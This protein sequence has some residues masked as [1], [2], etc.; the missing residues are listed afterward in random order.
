M[1]IFLFFIH[2]SL[3]TGHGVGALLNVHEVPIIGNNK[4]IELGLQEN[5]IVTIEPGFYENN[6][7][8]IRIENCVRTIKA[9]T[10]YARAGSVDFLTFEPL[11]YVPIQRELIDKSLLDLHELTWLN[12]Y[13]H[14]CARIIGDELTIVNKKDVHEWLLQQCQPL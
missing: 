5:M 13:H 12:S 4:S 1:L 14:E 3:G 9:N 6:Q 8:G 11:T 10:K 7:F 2:L